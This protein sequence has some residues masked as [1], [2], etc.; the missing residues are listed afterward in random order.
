MA[1]AAY[2]GQIGALTGQPEERSVD[3]VCLSLIEGSWVGVGDCEAAPADDRLDGAEMMGHDH[4][5]FSC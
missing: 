3:H 1:S 2:N 5:C 4:H